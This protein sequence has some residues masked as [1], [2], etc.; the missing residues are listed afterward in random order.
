MRKIFISLWVLSIIEII[1]RLSSA[2]STI[3]SHDQDIDTYVYLGSQLL[4]GKLMYVNNFNAKLPTVQYIFAPVALF[5]SIT[6]HR[7]IAFIYNIVGTT[8][9]YQGVKNLSNSNLLPKP[10]NYELAATGARIPYILLSQKNIGGLSEHLHTYSNTFLAI[11]FL[12][13]TFAERSKATSER[14]INLPQP[15]LKHNFY[16]LLAGATTGIAISIRPNLFF[17]CL[18]TGITIASLHSYQAK[19]LP[20]KTSAFL[21]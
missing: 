14:N 15:I 9:I 10:K 1:I 7:W 6:A 4:K 12:S 20:I 8:C 16:W 3:G 17:P 19:S 18:F 5:K 13:I 2:S 21:S 11:A